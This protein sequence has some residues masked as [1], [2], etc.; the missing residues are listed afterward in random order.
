MLTAGAQHVM[1][2]QKCAPQMQCHTRGWNLREYARQASE[3]WLKNCIGPEFDI[4]K[5]LTDEAP[6]PENEVPMKTNSYSMSLAQKCEHSWYKRLL[7][8]LSA[9][10]RVRLLSN[11]GPTQTWVT[12]P[13]LSFKNWNLSSREWLIAARRRLGMDVRTKKTRCS[14]CRFREIGLKGDH[15]LRCKGK[16]GLRMRHDAIKILL[17]RAFKQAGF[18]VK[19]EQGG[20]LLDRRRPGDIEVDNW[21]QQGNPTQTRWQVMG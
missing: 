16:M 1:S 19:L 15:A 10:N 8:S 18:N 9:D 2:L 21:T 17:S 14:N 7:G 6:V 4:D 13:P 11:S 5:Y 3:S 12:A 20:G